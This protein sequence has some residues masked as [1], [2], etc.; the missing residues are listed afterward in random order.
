M[1]PEVKHPDRSILYKC[2]VV[3]CLRLNPKRDTMKQTSA[4]ELTKLFHKSDEADINLSWSEHKLLSVLLAYV[5][6]TP[7]GY[8]CWPSTDTLK[9]KTGASKKT[10]ERNRTALVEA[11]WITYK[12]GRGPG[13]SN[14]YFIN[15]VKIEE[16][17]AKAGEYPSGS[18]AAEGEAPK[19]REYKRNTSGL[20]QG[21][22][23]PV[24]APIVVAPKAEP[25]QQ[26]GF[27]KQFWGEWYYSEH[28]YNEAKRIRAIEQARQLE[29]DPDCPF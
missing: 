25:V 10:I 22:K 18:A 2:Y 14:V 6:T 3:T 16:V 1:L 13:C 24:A 17:A 4:F 27:K 19:Q 9:R 5:S 12:S 28:D 20:K 8:K 21:N 26:S 23:A 11:G 29:N 15:G 7:E